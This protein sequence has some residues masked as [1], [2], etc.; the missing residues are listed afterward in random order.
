MPRTARSIEAGTVCH[1]LNRGNGRMRLF[2]KDGDYEAFERVLT[3]GF[4]RYP[5][6]RRPAGPRIHPPRS[7]PAAEDAKQSVM[8][9]FSLKYYKVGSARDFSSWLSF[10]LICPAKYR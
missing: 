3:E 10:E 5:V 6:D 9:P 4:S 8:S 1:M 2:H 7:R